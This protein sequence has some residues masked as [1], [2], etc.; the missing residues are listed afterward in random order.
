M[1]RNIIGR[2]VEQNTNI[3]GKMVRNRS[4]ALIAIIVIFCL[5][6]ALKYDTFLSIGNLRATLI[7]MT[8]DC[9]IA[10]GMCM[11]LIIGEI[12][13]SVGS[14]FALSGAV[15][16]IALVSG[17]PVFVAMILGILLGAL[18]GFTNAVVI[19][20][21]K[22]NFFIAT[23]GMMGITRGI[24]VI[25]AEGGISFLPAE[26]T[27]IGQRVVLGLQ[28]PV[29]ILA[30]LLVVFGILLMRHRF[31]RQLYYI[32]ASKKAATLSGIN[33]SMM[34]F[35]TYILVGSLAGFAGILNAA[36]FGAAISTSGTGMELRVIAASV[37]GGCSLAGGEGSVL[38]VFLGTVFMSLIS[39][40]LVIM[41]VSVYWHSIVTG[42]VLVLAVALDAFVRD[43][44]LSRLHQ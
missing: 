41:D 12:D 21:L 36:R 1:S 5:I 43:R 25:L 8:S 33:V 20:K 11:V 34:R 14:V 44:R 18:I 19:D 32:G 35:F 29:W 9:I 22:V 39:N 38:G 13:L 28:L 40:A 42:V 7:G 26:F 27:W 15:T 24:T 31:F 4:F 2:G 23:M 6:L 30:I 16:A 17:L 3:L 10:I 37:I